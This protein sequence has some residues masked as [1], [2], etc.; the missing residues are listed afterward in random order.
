MVIHVADFT[1]VADTWEQ[2]EMLLPHLISAMSEGRVF[3]VSFQGVTTATSSFTNASFVALLDHFSLAQIKATMKIID[4][5]HQ[6]NEMIR[7]RMNYV[8]SLAHA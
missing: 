2:G 4:S 3:D 5:T 7:H 8:A 6:I 1:G